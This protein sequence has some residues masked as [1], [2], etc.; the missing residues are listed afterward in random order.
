M[1]ILSCSVGP[2]HSPLPPPY[3]ATKQRGPVA[4]PAA[5]S[6]AGPSAAAPA[7]GVG[8]TRSAS[9]GANSTA[10]DSGLIGASDSPLM[11][12]RVALG[13]RLRGA[14]NFEAVD[15]V[16]AARLPT[17]TVSF[18]QLRAVLVCEHSMAD[19]MRVLDTD[20]R[21]PAAGRRLL[22]TPTECARNAGEVWARKQQL[23]RQVVSGGNPPSL[24][25]FICNWLWEKKSSEL[26]QRHRTRLLR[27]AA[28]L[29][30]GASLYR[31]K[32]R[33]AHGSL[34]HCRLSWVPVLCF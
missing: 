1:D 15:V 27:G 29:S 10:S 13:E 20:A 11:R 26:V 21:S 33:R 3:Y 34:L 16:K 6:L 32:L 22:T 4:A 8:G 25:N 14:D 17:S 31:N 18:A 12:L 2:H 23:D 30:G 9:S 24:V 28:S 7:S 5:G 19:C